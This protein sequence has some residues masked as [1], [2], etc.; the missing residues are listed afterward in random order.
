M[1]RVLNPNRVRR[2]EGTTHMKLPKEMVTS[3][4]DTMGIAVAVW[5]CILPF[6]GLLL[7][8]IIGISAAIAV[9]LLLLVG[10]LALCWGRCLMFVAR[11]YVNKRRKRFVYPISEQKGI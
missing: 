1:L 2:G 4:F 10:L 6:V 11:S 3:G 8:P 9:V 5:L 7:I